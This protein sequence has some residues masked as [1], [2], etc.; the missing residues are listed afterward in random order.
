[1]HVLSKHLELLHV[2]KALCGCPHCVNPLAL[3][4]HWL[5]CNCQM[6]AATESYDTEPAEITPKK[7]CP[8]RCACPK[9]TRVPINMRG[10]IDAA[11]NL[12]N[13]VSS[14]CDQHPTDIS[15]PRAEST[16]TDIV[17]VECDDPQPEGHTQRTCLICMDPDKDVE[18]LMNECGHAGFCCG[19][20][21]KL[22]WAMVGGNRRT[23]KAKQLK[24]TMVDCPVCRDSSTI[25]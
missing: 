12:K 3:Y 1:M 19:C 22:V 6:I 9:P 16:P 8:P 23:L 20:R 10:P 15:S 14:E 21:R 4:S 13:I 17:T 2:F 18:F 7:L 11:V 25:A 24:T 5:V